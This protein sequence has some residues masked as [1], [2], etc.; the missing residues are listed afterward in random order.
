[1]TVYFVKAA[2][3][4]SLV[5]IGTTTNLGLRLKALQAYEKERLRVIG[6]IDGDRSTESFIHGVF[7]QYREAGEWFRYEGDLKRYLE[8][9]RPEDRTFIVSLP[10]LLP[11][12]GYVP[13]GRSYEERMQELGED[14][15]RLWAEFQAHPDFA[16]IMAKYEPPK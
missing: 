6:T 14:R 7:A 5:K 11:Y 4:G 1:M 2:E 10:G 15:E 9:K 8:S 12:F 3:E 16:A 13:D